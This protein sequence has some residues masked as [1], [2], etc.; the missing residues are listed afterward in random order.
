[1]IKKCF[2]RNVKKLSILPKQKIV[3]LSM[4][5]LFF[6]VPDSQGIKGKKKI[7]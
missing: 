7:K 1:M 3:Y 5:L 2:I 6:T 4:Q